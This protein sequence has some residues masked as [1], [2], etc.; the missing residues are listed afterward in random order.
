MVKRRK[1][2]QN[3]VGEVKNIQVLKER[4]TGNVK[5]SGVKRLNARRFVKKVRKFSFAR[6]FGKIALW[7]ENQQA[8]FSCEEQNSGKRRKIAISFTGCCGGGVWW[9]RAAEERSIGAPARRPA[10]EFV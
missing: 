2:N 1:L 4:R 5:A 6:V 10:S 3:R 7:K 8:L 9:E